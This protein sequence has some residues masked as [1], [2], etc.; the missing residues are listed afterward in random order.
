MKAIQVSAFGDADQLKVVDIA[1]PEVGNGEVLVK[2][3]AAA[4]NPVDY[5]TRQG[6]GP[7]KEGQLPYVPGWDF[8]GI[9]EKVGEGVNNF[10]VGD[11]VFGL[12]HF[13]ALSGTYAEYAAVKAAEIVKKP[14]NISF[15]E[16]AAFPLVSLTA[17]QFL[18][19]H[20]GI[21]AGK[22]VLIQGAAGGVGHIAVQLAKLANAHVIGTASGANQSFLSNI[23]LD[24]FID[25]EKEDFTALLKNHEVDIV[26]D[27]VGGDMSLKSL[28]VMK[29]GGIL[30]CLPSKYKNDEKVLHRAKELDI[31]VKWPMMHPSGSD[32]HK[33]AELIEAGKLKTNVEKTYPLEEAAAA[34]KKVESY[35]A[36][37]KVV[38]EI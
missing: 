24:E 13:P 10:N 32:L 33:I 26:I 4:V 17:W 1:K 2:V 18:H 30:I 31:A 6:H 35:H 19:E 9:I 15:A 36:R 20:A 27:G 34:Q 11:E 14:G 3:K 16:A 12:S 21:S 28:H 38:L 29:P 7:V 23:G 22:R 5:K 25:Y 37:G 8:A